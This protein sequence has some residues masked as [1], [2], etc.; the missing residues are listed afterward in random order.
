MADQPDFK[1]EAYG[2][3]TPPPEPSDEDPPEPEDEEVD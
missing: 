2:I 3:V 1:I